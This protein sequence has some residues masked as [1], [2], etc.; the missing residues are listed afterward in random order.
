MH[1]GEPLEFTLVL[2]RLQHFTWILE[3]LRNE[4]ACLPS[5]ELQ[6]AQL[7]LEAEFFQLEGLSMRLEAIAAGCSMPEVQEATTAV[8]KVVFSYN[9]TATT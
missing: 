3:Y 2:H 5:S 8:N 6:V 7:Q 1:T 9:G 4:E